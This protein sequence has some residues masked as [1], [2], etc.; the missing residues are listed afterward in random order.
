MARVCRGVVLVNDLE[1]HR[2]HYLGARALAATVW[3]HCPVTR[4][5][6]PL[7]VLRSFTRAEL[8]VL[9]R[10]AGLLDLRVRRH[11][12]F[13]LVLEAHPGRESGTGR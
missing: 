10:R 9:G 5:D 6:G 7:S 3:R 13:R 1:R 11:F 8:E 4:Y 12:P 2:L